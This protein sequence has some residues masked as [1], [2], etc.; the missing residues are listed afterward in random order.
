MAARASSAPA[1]GRACA[2]NGERF[3]ALIV[4]AAA[5]FAPAAPALAECG[6]RDLFPLIAQTAPQELAAIEAEAEAAPFRRGLL[7]R[8]SRPGV[9]ASYVF[10]TLHLA[11]P[12]AARLKPAAAAALARAKTV[13]VESVETGAA[14]RRA[15]KRA[16]AAFRAATRAAP[17]ERPDALLDA[18]D[19]AR[20][21]ALAEAAGLDPAAAR[22]TKAG[23]LAVTLDL[24]ACARSG[25]YADALIMREARR[26]GQRLVG[27]ETMAEQLS[28]LG[29]LS[30]ETARA[31]L[32]ATLLQAERGED[33]VETALLRYAEDDPGALAAFMRAPEP[34]PGV[35]GSGTPQAF[36]ALLLD[37]RSARMAARA[38]P[39][40]E[41][42][43]AFVAVGAAHLPGEAGLLR[44]LE[45][46]GFVVERAQ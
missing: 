14:L 10:G 30:D 7:F 16:P 26:R 31:L 4:C 43:S 46:R 21:D 34:L 33:I 32:T 23:A 15:L 17:Q 24:P 42:G 5:A 29:P 8:V 45:R 41:T 37:A 9:A 35:A 1:A 18:D 3:R 20:L 38:A 22:A 2:T 27:L 36:L 28:G 39:L 19:L 6:G 13:A 12:R 40:L 44:R 11:D 25:D